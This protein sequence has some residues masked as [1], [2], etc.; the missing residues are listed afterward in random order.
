M[1]VEREG[2]RAETPFIFT[3]CSL[4]A[5]DK[6]LLLYL[7]PVPAPLLLPALAEVVQLVV[8]VLVNAPEA[9]V[10]PF[11]SSRYTLVCLACHLIFP[12]YPPHP[13]RCQYSCT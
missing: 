5:Y 6:V 1:L 7:L 12:V 10:A 11:P 13:Y 8:V 4:T 9:A 3:I 2:Q